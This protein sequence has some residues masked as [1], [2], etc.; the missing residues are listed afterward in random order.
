MSAAISYIFLY[1][2]FQ[3][4]HLKEQEERRSLVSNN[5]LNHTRYFPSFLLSSF[6]FPKWNLSL[7]TLTQANR[8]YTVFKQGMRSL[9][10]DRDVVDNITTYVFLIQT[11]N[12]SL[13]SGKTCQFYTTLLPNHSVWTRTIFVQHW[14]EWA[15]VCQV[16]WIPPLPFTSSSIISSSL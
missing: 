13:P 14:R 15:Y 16:P 10:K 6:F 3:K 9:I 8:K 2:F 11:V 5:S 1:I 12:H 4:N 7:L